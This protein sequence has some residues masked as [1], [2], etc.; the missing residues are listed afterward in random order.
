MSCC[1]V[2][3]HSRALIYIDV[4]ACSP[5]P[6]MK[7]FFFGPLLQFTVCSILH[8]TK[9]LRSRCHA[10]VRWH[11]PNVLSATR[12]HLESCWQN[13]LMMSVWQFD[14]PVYY[15]RCVFWFHIFTSW[16]PIHDISTHKK[17][18]RRIYTGPVV[19]KTP[20]KRFGFCVAE[21]AE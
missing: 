6:S 14:L 8:P 21:R 11:M 3:F 4:Y 5:C 20:L 18:W 2:R 17:K 12:L 1:V 15:V 16:L 10:C 13:S 9:V 19:T 7:V